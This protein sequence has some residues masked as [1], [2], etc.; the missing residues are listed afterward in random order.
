MTVTVEFSPVSALPDVALVAASG[1]VNA[2][3][4]GRGLGTLVE[5]AAWLLEQPYGHNEEHGPLAIFDE[6]V[7]TC[8]TKHAA[9]MSAANELGVDVALH[10]GTYALTDEIVTG[11]GEV[12]ERHGLPFVPTIHCFLRH[13]TAFVDLTEGNCNGKNVQI[14][15]YL[16]VD[17]VAVGADEGPHRRTVVE[18]LC[19]DHP[20]FA[21]ATPEDVERALAD[22]APAIV[23]ACRLA[24]A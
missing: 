5:A 19:A 9:F 20:G 11:V 22:C 23:T 21:A 10:W 6:G 12:L 2:A 3:L 4:V 8:V 15:E 24:S 14:T 16:R 18:S 1:P 17:E 13:G 7:G